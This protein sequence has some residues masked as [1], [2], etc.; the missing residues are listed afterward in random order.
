MPWIK[1][2]SKRPLLDS[3]ETARI[4]QELYSK[5]VDLAHTNRTLSL[6]RT[7]DGLV[8]DST[9]S[10][11][12]TMQGV[13]DAIILNSNY[14]FA[15]IF[16]DGDG[17]TKPESL[18]VAGCA[19]GNSVRVPASVL[20]LLHRAEMVC[21]R[22][23]FSS[24][25]MS[26][27]L[28][29]TAIDEAF[30]EQMFGI[31]GPV[32]LELIKASGVKS[33]CL[34]KLT[35]QDKLSGVL[36]VGIA[37]TPAEFSVD[38]IEQLGRVAEATGIAL[39]NKMLTQKYVTVL[40]K[41]QASNEK[42]KALDEA[43]DEFISMASHQLR[44][45]LTSVKGYISMVL[46]GDAGPLS[47]SQKELLTQSFLSSQRMVYL[48]SDLLNV[49]RLRTGK[50]VIEAKPTYLPDV[51]QGEI[52]QLTE[53]AG[54]RKLT[55]EFTPPDHFPTLN[56]DE[57]KIRQVIMNFVDN[58]L[59]Y[60]PA[61]GKVVIKLLELPQSVEFTV[62][63][64]GLGVPKEE[65]HHLFTKF[66]RAQNAQKARPDGTGLGLYMAKKIIT[67]QGGVIVFQS[68]EGKGSTFGFNLPRAA[69]EVA[70][71]EATQP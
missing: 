47:P 50:F 65:Q 45:P 66:Y 13:T 8:L 10:V 61:G 57:T 41:L 3:D 30:L 69:L 52:Q 70:K 44:T 64:T 19:L 18:S 71:A 5:N 42:L 14:L 48:I 54:A 20:E 2:S 11:T 24:K 15:M 4:A 26:E 22:P 34:V 16:A 43:K 58:A 12:A 49:S 32:M 53:M 39:D 17:T 27:L 60:T 63:D 1:K 59:Y 21:A 25:E 40:K 31:S 62:T 36:F 37:E 51:V 23:W 35:A 33:I 67:A 9:N 46:E 28:D 7:I 56:I 6:L 55:I 68:Q 29:I 38:Q